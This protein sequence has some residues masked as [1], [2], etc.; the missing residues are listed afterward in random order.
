VHR[1]REEGVGVAHDRADVQVVAPVLDGDVE[2]VP[3]GVEVGDDGVHPPVAVAVHHIAPVAQRQELGVETGIVG[4]RTR[5]G[6]DPDLG[7]ACV[8]R[9]RAD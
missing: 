4:P 8:V 5:V 7:L 6:P 3:A 9:T 2:R 1:R